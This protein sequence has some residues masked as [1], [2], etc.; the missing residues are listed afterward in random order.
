MEKKWSEMTGAEKRAERFRRWKY[1]EDVNFINDEAKA[2]YEQRVQRFID[3]VELREPDRVP[4]IPPSGYIPAHYAGYT[5]K[6][7]MYDADKVVK[8]W[9]KYIKDFDHDTIPSTKLLRH[10]KSLD[11]LKPKGL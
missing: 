1:P 3:V 11:I 4:V 6:E 2:L 8:A 10:G 9:T 7:A 5:I